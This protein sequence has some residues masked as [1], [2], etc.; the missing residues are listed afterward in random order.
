M[1]FDLKVFN[2]IS[3]F[4]AMNPVVTIGIFDGVHLGH[5]EILRRIRELALTYKGE[6]VVIT[7][8][9]HPRFVLQPENTGLKL[10]ASLKE[11]IS[12]I[13]KHGIDNL[14][15]LP[16]TQ[17]LANLTYDAFVC[18]YIVDKIGARHIVVGYNHHFGKDRKGTFDN[19][20]II[21]GKLG[22]QAERLPQV[23]IDELTVS[24]SGIRHMLEEGQIALANKALGYPYF[25]SGIVTEGNQVGRQLGYP[26]A[27]ILPE[28]TKKLLPRNGVYAVT[29]TLQNKCYYGMLSIGI[30][31]T[32]DIPQ[33][34]QVIEVHIFD[35][36]E[37]IYNQEI[38][39]SF[40]AWMRNEI[41]FP[42]I[43]ALKNQM[44]QDKKDIEHY[45]I[46]KTE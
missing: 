29:I 36:N 16:F 40:H 2:D 34:D 1:Y 17:Q 26:T 25:I 43:Q 18:E 9:P 32:L 21:A 28:E 13:E 12:L 27:N 44:D 37:N 11:K 38:T 8:W 4:R 15:V 45:F 39:V 6:S 30:R 3:H 20:V 5:V 24:S 7:L 46:N 14:I 35:F 23:F 19:L 41:K 33:H 10:L 31:P 42:T 22:I